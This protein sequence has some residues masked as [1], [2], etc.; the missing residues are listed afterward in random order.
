MRKVHYAERNVCSL[1]MLKGGKRG[2]STRASMACGLANTLVQTF[3]LQDEW[4]EK[5]LLCKA[6]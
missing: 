5:I 6:T 3:D 4:R 2:V 1:Q